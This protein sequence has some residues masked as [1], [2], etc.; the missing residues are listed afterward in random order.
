MRVNLYNIPATLNLNI[1]AVALKK[2]IA[3]F[4]LKEDPCFFLYEFQSDKSTYICPSI[5]KILGH[6]NRKYK[7]KSFLFYLKIIHPL[8]ISN[9]VERVLTLKKLAENRNKNITTINYSGF[10]VRIRHRNGN[11]S[12]CRIHLTIIRKTEQ[13]NSNSLLGF[14]ENDND[15]SEDNTSKY[16][17]I[18]SREKEIF[19]LLSIGKSAKMIA[20][21]LCISENTVISHRK[22][23]IQ[24]LR[25]KNS[26]ELIKRG[27][28]LNILNLPS[29]SKSLLSIP[30]NE[31]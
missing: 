29:N 18:S 22:N 5:T 26:A 15:V 23:L 31:D 6:S 25:V 27:I 28:E 9:L 20:N 3:R 14:I 13:R 4:K 16:S 7:N 8:D 19:K 30:I 2:V 12:K 10:S 21:N 24:K 17:I 11:W 1:D